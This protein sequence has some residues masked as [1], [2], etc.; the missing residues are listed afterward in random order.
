MPSIRELQPLISEPREELGV[1]Y[2]YWLDLKTNEHKATLAKAAIALANHGGGFIVI[3]FAEQRPELQSHP[4]LSEMPAV[5]QDE[6]NAAICRYATP[7]FHCRVDYVT[8]PKTNVVHP[9]ITV[10]GNLTVPVMSTRDCPKVID[11]NR[12]YIRKPGPK[13]EEP[14]TGEEWRALLNRCQRANREDML[15]AIRSIVSGRVELQN[16]SP[17]ALSELKTYCNDAHKRW[18][19]LVANE[20]ENSPARFPYGYY[21][22]GVSLVGAKPAN[23]LTEIK[24]RL[25]IARRIPLTGCPPFSETYPGWTANP[26]E[27]F[28]EAWNGQPIHPDSMEREPELCD[29]WRVSMDGKLYSIRGYFEDGAELIPGGER[30]P[31][32]E[33]LE[34]TL[35]VRRIAEGLLF[36]W[37]FTETFD[38][39]D[40]IAMQC[41]F[42]GLNGRRLTYINGLNRRLVIR[43]DYYISSTD[44]I[45]LTKQVTPKQVQDNLAEVLHPLLLPLYERFNFFKLQFSLVEEELASLLGRSL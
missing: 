9:V 44:E 15:D 33:I 38:G 18:K 22:M 21:E 32:G 12:C 24:D 45:P 6:V 41:R 29:F 43:E 3:G 35:P 5:T 23:G 17:D 19:E 39:V 2:K 20:P 28:V 1:E 30:I 42:T 7:E 13:S 36:A 27:N 14:Q 10:P 25:A 11:K 37:Q 40:A 31:G 8:H 4:C 16:P 34:V 26:H